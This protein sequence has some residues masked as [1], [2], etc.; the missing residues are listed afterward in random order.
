M[1]AP[2]ASMGAL[3]LRA[4]HGCPNLP[5]PPWATP[6]PQCPLPPVGDPAWVTH[7]E[8]FFWKP[9]GVAQ[10]ALD[11]STRKKMPTWGCRECRE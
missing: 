5:C 8:P 7:A 3:T 1:G 6:S 2:L 10:V 11:A 9:W 4:R